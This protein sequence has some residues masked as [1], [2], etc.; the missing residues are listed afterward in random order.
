MHGLQ[1]RSQ[2]LQSIKHTS[3]G[4]GIFP[5]TIR[6]LGRFNS[7]TV[8]TGS[9]QIISMSCEFFMTVRATC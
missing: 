7:S 5:V 1:V 4:I 3:V 8:D 6:L 9:S 2:D